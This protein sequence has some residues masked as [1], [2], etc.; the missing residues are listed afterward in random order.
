MRPS[1]SSFKLERQELVDVEVVPAELPLSVVD[2]GGELDERQAGM[3]SQCL[4]VALSG[5]NHERIV[6]DPMSV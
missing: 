1:I 6:P 5:R 3:F 4:L 2:F